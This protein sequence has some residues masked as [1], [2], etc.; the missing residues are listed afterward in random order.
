MWIKIGMKHWRDGRWDCSCEE[1]TN[2]IFFGTPLKPHLCPGRDIGI[3][4]MSM[5]DIFARRHGELFLMYQCIELH[6]H[7]QYIKNE[8]SHWVSQYVYLNSGMSQCCR[9]PN[10]DDLSQYRIPLAD[11]V[12]SY[13]IERV[14]ENGKYYSGFIDNVIDNYKRH[15]GLNFMSLVLAE[16]YIHDVMQKYDETYVWCP[17][18]LSQLL[19]FMAAM[20]RLPKL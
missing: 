18:Y 13:K 17:Y 3:T 6:F 1:T 7:L 19:R 2:H 4:K 8:S 12:S 20:N 9:F 14:F 5:W 16:D 11:G 15:C 10:Y